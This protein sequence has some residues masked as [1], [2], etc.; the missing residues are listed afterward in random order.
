VKLTVVVLSAASFATN[1]CAPIS[2]TVKDYAQ[3]TEE[4]KKRYEKLKTSD[5]VHLFLMKCYMSGR[6]LGA[7]EVAE[8]A[9]KILQLNIQ[10]LESR[11]PYYEVMFDILRDGHYVEH[12]NYHYILRE[13]H[14]KKLTDYL[15]NKTGMDEDKASLAMHELLRGLG[16][17]PGKFFYFYILERMSEVERTTKICDHLFI[18]LNDVIGEVTIANLWYDHVQEM[19]EWFFTPEKRETA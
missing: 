15:A 11:L 8:A 7:P 14:N 4:L 10:D 16:D 5:D 2:V 3:A 9:K 1:V 6:E 19:A 13:E 18:P 17:T 12:P